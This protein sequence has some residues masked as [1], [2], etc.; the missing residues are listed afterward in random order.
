LNPS[1]V[2]VLE[3]IKLDTKLFEKALGGLDRQA[4]VRPAVEHA[5][6]VIWIAGHLASARFGMAALLGEKR[7]SPLAPVFG[8]GAQVPEEAALPQVDEV[9]AA[10]REISE[11]LPTRLAEAT[12]AQLAAP[13]PRRFPGGDQSVLGGL[14]FLTYHEGYHLGQLALIRKSLGLPG[15]VDA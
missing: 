8:K 9:L 4:L 1:V 5:N 13:S 2:P 15:L 11:I 10:W 6:P 12:E 3:I 14:A 7:A